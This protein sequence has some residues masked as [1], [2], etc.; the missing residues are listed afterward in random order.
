M[1]RSYPRRSPCHVS[2]KAA[3]CLGHNLL[4]GIVFFYQ[5]KVQIYRNVLSEGGHPSVD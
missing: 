5:E 1:L 3:D 4:L 2:E